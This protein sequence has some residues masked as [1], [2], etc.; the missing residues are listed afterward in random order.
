MDYNE[1]F[2]PQYGNNAENGGPFDPETSKQYEFGAKGEFFK[3]ALQPFI[4]IYQSTKKNVLQSAPRP[5][6][7]TGRKPSAK[8]GAWVWKWD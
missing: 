2:S 5:D 8:C 3:G 7:P 4:T 6:F 1:G